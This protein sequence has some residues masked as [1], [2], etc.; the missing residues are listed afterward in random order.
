MATEID[1]LDIEQLL[2]EH[3]ET[4]ERIQE[5]GLRPLSPSLKALM[6]TLRIY[7]ILMI[8]AVVVNVIQSV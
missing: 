4:Q 7:V 5:L 2:Q 6:W 8:V 1:A 3:Y